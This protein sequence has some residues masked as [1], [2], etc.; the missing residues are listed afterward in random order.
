M[1][2][3]MVRDAYLD[4]GRDRRIAED[5]DRS[6]GGRPVQGRKGVGKLAGFGIADVMEVQTVYKDLDKKIGKR[7]LIW[8]S[9]DIKDLYKNRNKPAPVN[10]IFVGPISGLR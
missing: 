9:I 4:V 10:L 2:W 3:N 5:T 1:T 8:F 7:I 6:P